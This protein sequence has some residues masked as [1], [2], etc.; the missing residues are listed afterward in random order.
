MADKK[1]K[2]SQMKNTT[3]KMY[4]SSE[5]SDP[6]IQGIWDKPLVVADKI[7]AKNE[8][9]EN[10]PLDIKSGINS[11][12]LSDNPLKSETLIDKECFNSN[13]EYD[14]EKKQL[15]GKELGSISSVLDDLLI[16]N[17]TKESFDKCI[18]GILKDINSDPSLTTQKVRDLSI[19]FWDK[20]IELHKKRDF[21]LRRLIYVSW[22]TFSNTI[23]IANTQLGYDKLNDM[24][25]KI[26]RER[27]TESRK[28]LK[29][30]LE[31]ALDLRHYAVSLVKFLGEL[32]NFGILS[33]KVIHSIKTLLDMRITPII[34]ECFC[35]FFKTVGLKMEIELGD[36]VMN[37]CFFKLVK[38]L[39]MFHT[40]TIILC[41]SVGTLISEVLQLRLS[42]KLNKSKPL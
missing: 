33:T 29:A 15:I 10:L 42:L 11:S 28:Q 20:P 25:D 3:N 7:L 39:T 22:K 5:L 9:A 41:P 4:N 23:F 16:I 21:I 19:S 18:I 12:I 37:E 38:I 30:E 34:V 40:R 8:I 6:S 17:V 26:Q 14:L 32:V 36:V 1:K 2:K 27:N 24:M 35:E 31:D 13:H